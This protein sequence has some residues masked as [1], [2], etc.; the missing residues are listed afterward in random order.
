MP[1]SAT[2]VLHPSDNVEILTEPGVAPAGHKIARCDIPKGAPVRKYGQI[3][4]YASAAIQTGCHVHTQNLSLGSG[5][6]VTRNDGAKATSPH[7]IIAQPPLSFQGYR[8]TGGTV[9]TRN[10][11]ALIATVNCS[12]TVIR[13]AAEQINQS[14]LLAEYANVDGV[15]ALAHGSGCGMNASGPGWDNLNRVIMGYAAHPNVGAAVFVGLGCEMMQISRLRRSHEE[16]R[17]AAQFHAISIQESGSTQATINAV[18][19]KVQEILPATNA[20]ERED[21]PISELTIGLQCGA[22]D[23]FSGITANPALGYASDLLVSMGGTSLLSETPE[24][25]G[26]EQLLLTRAS[27]ATVAD[28]L[29]ERIE[30]WENYAAQH[31]AAL[32]NNPSPGNKAGGLTTIFEKSLGA[33]AKSGTAPLSDVVLYGEKPQKKGLV[34]MD[35]PG[36]DPVSVTG[37]IAAGAQ[38]ILFTTGRGSTFGSKPAP[39]IKLASNDLLFSNM[40]DDMDLGCGDILSKGTAL[41]QKGEEILTAIITTAS[42]KQTQSET[43]GLGDHENVPWHIGAVL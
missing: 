4:G 18:V 35:S 24:I 19:A 14:G 26:A 22:S 43:Q 40:R 6:P 25:Y 1:V 36:F 5:A 23:G 15:F 38:L 41:A 8:R 42:G 11:I 39:T 12:A 28:K 13:R 33:V 20:V 10:Y 31:G 29:R 32:D 21:C 2:L 34:F 3:I 30:W 9:G 37:Q 16:A 27:S 7:E 17:N